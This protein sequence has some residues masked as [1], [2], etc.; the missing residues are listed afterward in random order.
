LEA[1]AGQE[2][3]ACIRLSGGALQA[4]NSMS[5]SEKVRLATLFKELILYYAA[6]KRLPIPPLQVVLQATDTVATAFTVCEQEKRKLQERTAELEEELEELRQKLIAEQTYRQ[7]I[8][9]LSKQL[10][11]EKAR[12][13]QLEKQKEQLRDKV[14]HLE[15]QIERL[16]T[17]LCPHVDK[18]K[19]LV[20]GDSRAVVEIE[21]LCWRR[22]AQT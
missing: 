2:A 5:R 16:A 19:Q 22:K 11:E 6:S 7:Q 13:Q 9:V 21:A 3:R 15:G 1:E 17:I 14:K 20:A 18:L 12:A 8:E 4:W 10:E